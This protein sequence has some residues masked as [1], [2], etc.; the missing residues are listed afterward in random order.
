MTRY[1]PAQVT[2]E[3]FPGLM[4][5]LSLGAGVQSTTLAILAASGDLEPLDG[6]IFADTGWEPASV[7]QHLARLD[8][9]VLSP[10]GIR[11]HRVA[12]GN[13][14]R[15]ALD[16]EHRFASMPLYVRNPDG[17][18]GMGRRQCTSEYKLKPIRRKVRELLGAPPRPDGVA[19]RVPAG[20]YA[21]QWVGISLD[22]RDRA[23]AVQLREP[24]YTRSRFPLLEMELT[25]QHCEAINRAAGFETVAKSACIGCPF[26]TN[27][28][29]RRM[30]DETP[31]EFADAAEF[32][33]AIRHG[34][35][36]ALAQGQELR[37]EMFLHRSR[38]PLDQAPIER[39][40]NREWA[41]RQGDLV[42]LVALSEFEESLSDDSALNGCS[43]FA[44]QTGK[45]V[46]DE[47]HLEEATA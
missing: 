19:G 21:E 28:Q 14:R 43:P 16:P 17:G 32:D 41:D 7:Y 39:V 33:A 3:E 11:L 12:A 9:E 8:R 40:T 35:A 23:D 25:R 13:I 45:S 44:C 47:D 20:R 2:R 27:R 4:R 15:D 36:R 34:S 5:V 29:W 18:E 38:V 10:A 46:D 22:E 6:A 37:G 26:H 42:H 31:A 30:R 24:G 1:Y